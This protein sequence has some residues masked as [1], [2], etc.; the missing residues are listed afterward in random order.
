MRTANSELSRILRLASSV[1]IV[2]ASVTNHRAILLN[3]SRVPSRGIAR[4]I[5]ES[6]Q[7]HGL[8]DSNARKDLIR[9]LRVDQQHDSPTTATAEDCKPAH[10]RF[11]NH[12]V[13]VSC[14]RA[15]ARLFS[16]LEPE[17]RVRVKM[18]PRVWSSPTFTNDPESW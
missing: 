17:R 12:G 16:F 6:A 13:R 8:K 18:S 7:F 10:P 5:A 4:Q 11:A 14:C 15:I 3:P 9:Q 2:S 1:A